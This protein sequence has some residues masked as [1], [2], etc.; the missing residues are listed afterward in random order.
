MESLLLSAQR[1]QNEAKRNVW[2]PARIYF[3]FYME[4]SRPVTTALLCL[5]LF[6]SFS[7]PISINLEPIAWEI[8]PYDWKA[9]LR[10]VDI[11]QWI[12]NQWDE[13]YIWIAGR[14]VCEVLSSK[15][16]AHIQASL[17]RDYSIYRHKSSKCI[18]ANYFKPYCIN[19]EMRSNNQNLY[20]CN[21]LYMFV[22][23][24][25]ESLA[26]ISAPEISLFCVFGSLSAS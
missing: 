21:S 1:R 18:S 26:I 13:V 15:R 20:V 24:F 5:K 7:P 19:M 3:P 16:P 25:Q 12:G 11:L 17:P 23:G 4:D 10:P 6:F 14:S 2:C 22:C 8:T 9:K